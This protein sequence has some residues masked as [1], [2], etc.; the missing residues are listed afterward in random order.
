MEAGIHPVYVDCPNLKAWEMK[1]YVELAERLG[2]IIKIVDPMQISA[3][4]ANIDW[5]VKANDTVGRREM[6]KAVNRGTLKPML[7]AFDFLPDDQ[8]PIEVIRSC[9]RGND[10]RTVEAVPSPPEALN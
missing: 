4:F 7:D 5:L 9:S 8:D 6:G 1:P 3:S 10:V 2:Y